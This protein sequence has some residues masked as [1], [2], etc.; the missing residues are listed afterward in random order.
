MFIQFFE[1]FFSDL[2]LKHFNLDQGYIGIA[3]R[4]VPQCGIDLQ[5]L[6]QHWLTDFSLEITMGS[7]FQSDFVK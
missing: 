4:E 7:N 6:C 1:F 2:T 5:V 3:V